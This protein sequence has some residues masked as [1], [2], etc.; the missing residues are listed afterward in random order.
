MRQSLR[1]PWVSAVVLLTVS[2]LSAG[3][4][5]GERLVTPTESDSSGLKPGEGRF[6]QSTVRYSTGAQHA[7]LGM[8]LGIRLVNLNSAVGTEVN[9]DNV[10]LQRTSR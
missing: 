2:G 9:F 1:L 6:L 8:P 5:S 4:P 3:C 10:R 7:Q